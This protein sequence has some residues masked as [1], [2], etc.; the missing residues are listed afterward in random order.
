MI[1][2]NLL[3]YSHLCCTCCTKNFSIWTN[4]C[5]LA[6]I[7]KKNVTVPTYAGL[8]Y[9]EIGRIGLTFYNISHGSEPVCEI[10]YFQAIGCRCSE[11]LTAKYE[12]ATVWTPYWSVGAS[13]SSEPEL[14][15]PW[16]DDRRILADYNRSTNGT[17]CDVV[18]SCIVD[19][20]SGVD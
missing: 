4:A 3:D 11:R 17:V 12:A 20:N 13:E 2:A 16:G 5:L 15:D 10:L 19:Q 1:T 18:L 14:R 6:N 9:C 7:K 8:S